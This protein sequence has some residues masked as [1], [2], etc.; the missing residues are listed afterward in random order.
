VGTVAVL[1]VETAAAGRQ[2]DI[3]VA[4]L[5]VRIVVEDRQADITVAVL[6]VDITVAV[7]GVDITVGIGADS[8]IVIIGV[9][10]VGGIRVS[11]SLTTTHRHRTTIT[12]AITPRTIITTILRR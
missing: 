7:L 10:V 4:D 3:E 1:Q 2:A 11:R 6:G 9:G 12:M 8:I 5:L